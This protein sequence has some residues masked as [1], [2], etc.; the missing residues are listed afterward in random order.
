M[1]DDDRLDDS[2]VD[3]GAMGTK[4]GGQPSMVLV[5]PFTVSLPPVLVE[6][7]GFCSVLGP[8]LQP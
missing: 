4:V 7:P 2:C 6:F 1:S 8:L 3:R 5:S